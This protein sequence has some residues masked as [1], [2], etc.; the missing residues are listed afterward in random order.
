MLVCSA[1]FSVLQGTGL[2]GFNR[3]VVGIYMDFSSGLSG[4][5]RLACV[6]SAMAEGVVVLV[7][8]FCEH[9]T[10]RLYLNV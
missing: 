6:T 1:G 10:R 4:F 9:H 5:F 8:G 3:P 7:A 2:N